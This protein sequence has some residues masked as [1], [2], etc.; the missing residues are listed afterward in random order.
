MFKCHV[1]QST[2]SIQTTT[3]EI[4]QI[5]EKNYL[6]KNI[7]VEICTQCGEEFFDGET[8]DKIRQMLHEANQPVQTMSVAVV[9]Y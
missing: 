4:F 6:I 5:N 3:T 2:T 9:S 1:C 8:M 7:P